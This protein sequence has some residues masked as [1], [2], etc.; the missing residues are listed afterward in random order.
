[1][2]DEDFVASMFIASTHSYILFFTDKGKCYRV[3]VHEIPQG[4]R[5]AKGK[6]MV[7]LLEIG[8][9]ENIA[10]YI[11]VPDF[12]AD[13]YLTM[14]TRKGLIKKTHLSKYSNIHRGGIIAIK[15]RDDDG[16]ITAMLTS[17]T[18]DIILAKRDG[19]AIRF[20][21][22]EVRPMGRNAAGVK[23]VTCKGD[24]EVVEMVVVKRESAILAVT[25]NGYGKRT[26]ISDF[27]N[28]HRG[29]QGVALIPASGRNG[30]VVAAREVIETD[31]VMMITRNGMIIRCPVRGISVIGRQAQG[32][33]VINLNK[34][35]AL[36]DVA[37]LAGEK[38][39]SGSE[40]AGPE[41]EGEL[42]DS[43]IREIAEEM[44]EDA[45]Y[46]AE[47][48]VREAELKKK[49]KAS[50]RKKSATGKKGKGRK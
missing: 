36:V 42:L 47:E 10:A 16:L 5:L 50:P 26:R 13:C 8:G 32:V 20:N 31:E 7:N 43:E 1:M 40:G 46:E 49:K 3:K 12:G 24:D 2:K 15:L 19:K 6:A 17:G 33:K 45:A 9:D 35:D 37:L 11:P 28:K 27:R 41:P 30:P 18:D 38:D 21:E 29:G 4:G 23:G 22:K 44:A 14:A 48:E 25:E 39:E 34:G